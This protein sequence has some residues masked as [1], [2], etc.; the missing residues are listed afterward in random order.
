[1]EALKQFRLAVVRYTLIATAVCAAGA[2]FWDA[3]AAMGLLMGGLAG[4]VGFWITGY[5]VQILASPG[6]DKLN[7]YA[8]K[9]TF[10]RLFFY[11]LAVSK[12]Y[13]LDREGYRGLVAAVL[14]IFLVQVVMVAIAFTTLDGTGREED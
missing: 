5:N 12:A 10:V 1:M 14:G 13:T 7:Y 2:W 4:A 11:A 6:T 9:W 3:A 8:F